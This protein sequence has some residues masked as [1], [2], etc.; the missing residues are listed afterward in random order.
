MAA[1]SSVGV[2]LAA[3]AVW[4][5][6]LAKATSTNGASVSTRSFK[7]DDA[8]LSGSLDG[9]A[10]ASLSWSGAVASGSGCETPEPGG[11]SMAG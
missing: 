3:L 9:A 11:C 7:A 6:T 10:E 2:G 1:N 5:L 8:V 4:L